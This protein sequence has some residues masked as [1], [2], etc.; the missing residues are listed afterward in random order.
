MKLV[1]FFSLDIGIAIMRMYALYERSRKVLVLY[2]TVGAVVLVVACVSMGIMICPHVPLLILWYI[3][4]STDWKRRKIFKHA[5]TH[6]LCLRIQSRSVSASPWRS[7]R[8]H[9]T[10]TLHPF[11]QNYSC[12]LAEDFWSWRDIPTLTHTDFGIVWTGVLVFDLLVFGMTLYKSIVLPRSNR[13]NILDIF[14]RDG[15]LYLSRNTFLLI[16]IQGAIYF[17]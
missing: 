10:Q 13:G 9:I 8:I 14:F 1:I 3:V 7:V 17:G 2:I 12:V 11:R 6:R 5:H 15:E 16:N 4:D